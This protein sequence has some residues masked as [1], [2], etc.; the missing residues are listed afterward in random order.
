MKFSC[1]QQT[2]AKALNIVSE[3]VTSRTTMPILKGIIV[4]SVLFIVPS[5]KIPITLFSFKK[6][7]AI[8]S[9]LPSCFFLFTAMF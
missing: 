7:Q 4:S 6:S 9:D 8:L 1:N 3:A 2:L 5:G